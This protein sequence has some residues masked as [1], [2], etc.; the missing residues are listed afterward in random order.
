[1]ENAEAGTTPLEVMLQVMNWFVGE[2]AAAMASEDPKE[3]EGARKLMVLAKDAA[4]SAAPFVHPR[5]A[6][7]EH[8]GKDG[9]DLVPTSGV[10]LVPGVMSVEQW[11]AAAAAKA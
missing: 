10:L 7:I 1:M 8:T 5:L 4:Q 3:R 9:K 6:A 2:A 11:E